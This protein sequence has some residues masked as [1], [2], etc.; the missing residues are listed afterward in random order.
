M[1][2]TRTRQRMRSDGTLEQRPFVLVVHRS[3]ALRTTLLSALDFEGFDVMTMV[4]VDEAAVI[5]KYIPPHAMVVDRRLLNS[6]QNECAAAARQ[7]HIPMIAFDDTAMMP[8]IERCLDVGIQPVGWEGGVARL[9]QMLHEVALP[10][11]H[12]LSAL[13]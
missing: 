7:A 10:R 5:V 6:A 11:A 12:A 3:A 9:L 1:T 13:A 8:P 2:S 4:D